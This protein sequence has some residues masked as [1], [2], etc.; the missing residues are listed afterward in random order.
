MDYQAHNAYVYH[1]LLSSDDD[2]NNHNTIGSPPFSFCIFNEHMYFLSNKNN[3]NVFSAASL[4][5]LSLDTAS[6]ATTY[7]LL[8]LLPKT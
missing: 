4:D 6:N 3:D 5:I 8:F 2:N 7:V 1:T